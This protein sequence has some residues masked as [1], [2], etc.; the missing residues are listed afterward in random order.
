LTVEAVLVSTCIVALAARYNDLL[1]VTA[2][3]RLGLMV[4][5]VPDML[6]GVGS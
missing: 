6:L 2:G 4:A 5:N 1:T 3:T